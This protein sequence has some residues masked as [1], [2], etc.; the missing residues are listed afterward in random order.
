[1][2]AGVGVGRHA[3]LG[4][5]RVARAVALTAAPALRGWEMSVAGEVQE[6]GGEG[7]AGRGRRR[8]GREGAGEG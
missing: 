6:G 5:G 4:L 1:M 3:G 8:G 2:G 7:V